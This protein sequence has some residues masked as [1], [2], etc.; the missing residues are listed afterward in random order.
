MLRL[1]TLQDRYRAHVVTG[2]GVVLLSDEDEAVLR[3]PVYEQVVPLLDGRL[4]ADEIVAGLAS[5]RLP[6]EVYY[7]L[8][9]LEAG[10]HLIDATGPSVPTG[11]STSPGPQPIATRRVAL[12]AVG[13][14][15]EAECAAALAAHGGTRDDTAAL[16]LVVADSYLRP[17]LADSNTDALRTGRPWL[18]V[19]VGGSAPWVGPL[20]RPGETCCWQCMADRLRRNRPLEYQLVQ[21]GAARRIEGPASRSAAVEAAIA[22]LSCL[23]DEAL[24]GTITVLHTRGGV[25]HRERVLRRPQCPVCGDRSLY[26]RRAATPG[27]VTDVR[28]TASGAIPLATLEQLVAPLTGVVHDERVLPTSLPGVVHVAV[29]R[30]GADTDV[31]RPLLDRGLR[32][33]SGKGETPAGARVSAL[34]EAIERYCAVAQG[35]EPAV[36]ATREELAGAAIEPND[37]MQF[38]AVQF[39]ERVQRNQRGGRFEWIP[40]SLDARE[41]LDWT[42]VRSLSSGTTRYLPTALL[43]AGHAEAAADG[44]CVWDS[45]GTAAGDSFAA[46]VLGGLL[47]LIERDALAIWWYNRLTRPAVAIE[48][49]ADPWCDRMVEHCRVS[50]REVWALDLTT[51]LRI[52]CIAAVSRRTGPGPEALVFGFAADLDARVALRRALAELGQVLIHVTDAGRAGRTLDPTLARWLRDATCVEQPYLVPGPVP[53]VRTDALEAGA[54]GDPASDIATV[55][56]RLARQGLE[57]FMLDQTRPD[58]GVPV[59]RVVVP[60]L[61]HFRAR[62]APGRLYSVAVTMGWLPRPHP[63]AALNPMGFFL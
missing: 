25:P 3:G 29:A 51:D 17:E 15:S 37:C 61:R 28:G 23:T 45:S 21:R 44:C 49:A 47:E 59:A 42:P 56:D 9:Q 50:H 48:S 11:R 46:A 38:S 7:A 36:R 8:A 33:A 24:A 52:P 14:V 5:E 10:G 16:T 32:Q 20:L 6:A 12:R 57:S 54:S 4:T 2:E 43:Y 60:G 30:Y 13:D 34:A 41:P 53:V 27:T 58:V 40:R 62:F 31:D 35:D 1:P 22:A 26:T 55:V 39:A 63:E 18:L 19:R